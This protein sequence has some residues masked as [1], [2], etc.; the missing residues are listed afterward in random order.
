MLAQKHSSDMTEDEYLKFADES[1]IKHE[2][3]NGKIIAMT[4]ATIRH[5]VIINNISYS[6]TGQLANKKCLV[7]T[8]DTRIKIQIK[9]SYRYPDIV[10]VCG[11]IEYLENRKDTLTNP[12]VLIEVLSPSTALID[13][14]QKLDEYTQIPPLQEYII[15][16]QHDYKAERYL[17]QT[18]EDWLYSRA[19]G[20]DGLLHILSIDCQL[21]LSEVY[22]KLDLLDEEDA[23]Q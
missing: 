2:F 18:G 15:I 16:S 5:N 6:I 14:N 21:A 4:G 7:T 23:T 17:R 3:V 12:I 19:K 11:K 8:N 20:L 9:E 22:Q 10:V 1:D 13:Y